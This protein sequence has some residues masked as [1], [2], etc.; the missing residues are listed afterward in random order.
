MVTF[1]ITTLAWQ[2][3]QIHE[4]FFYISLVVGGMKMEENKATQ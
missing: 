1:F 4:I 2:N 3:G